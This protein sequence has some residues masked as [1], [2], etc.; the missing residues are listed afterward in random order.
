VPLTATSTLS[1]TTRV[2]ETQKPHDNIKQG[3]S[4]RDSARQGG[5]G[6]VETGGNS[7]CSPLCSSSASSVTTLC[8]HWRHCYPILPSPTHLP[9]PR[10]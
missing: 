10:F 9:T 7:Q 8:F 3:T 6:G 4:V 5:G 1:G 2:V